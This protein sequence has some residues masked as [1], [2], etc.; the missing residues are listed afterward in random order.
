MR[1]FARVCVRASTH[2]NDHFA[3]RFW[4]VNFV[5]KRLLIFRTFAWFSNVGFVFERSLNLTAYVYVTVCVR[6]YLYVC[7]C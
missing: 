7:V 2:S 5:F 3:L 6:A 4:D 1:V